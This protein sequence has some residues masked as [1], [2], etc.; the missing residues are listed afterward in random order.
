M[1]VFVYVCFVVLSCLS[2]DSCCCVWFVFVL[3][4]FVWCVL[5][6]VNWG[7]CSV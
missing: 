2:S 1:I 5:F 7:V 3:L 6:D 4:L